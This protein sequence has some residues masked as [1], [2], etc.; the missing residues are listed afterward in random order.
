MPAISLPLV[1]KELRQ[2]LR[3]RATLAVENLYV[4]ALVVAATVSVYLANQS[5][6]PLWQ[7]G[8]DAFYAIAAM[9]SV[10]L[11]LVA[12][13][14][15]GAMVSGERE[16]KT[17]DILLAAPVRVRQVVRSKLVAAGLIVLA[18]LLLSLPISVIF[19]LLGGLTWPEVAMAY[20][21]TAVWL[22]LALSIGLLSSAMF[23]RT[24]AAVPFA[25]VVTATLDLISLGIAQSGWAPSA[26]AGLGGLALLQNAA[27]PDFFSL[28]VPIGAVSLL[29]C[30]SLAIC[31]TESAL[32]RVRLA[33]RRRAASQRIWLMVWLCLLSLLTL[34]AAAAPDQEMASPPWDDLL[35]FL[36]CQAGLIVV[37][38]VVFVSQV[39]RKADLKALTGGRVGPM[40]GI[41][42]SGPLAGARYVVLLSVLILVGWTAIWWVN[43]PSL[44]L[45]GWR[46][47]LGT[48][49]LVAGI[50]V[51]AL[52]AQFAAL[53]RRVRR[54]WARR[55]LAGVLVA[56]FFIGPPALQAWFWR[57]QDVPPPSSVV[58]L[59]TNPFAGCIVSFDPVAPMHGS[60]FA[61]G[62]ESIIP[63]GACTLLFLL[64]FG[65]C[66]LF[67]LWRV[68]LGYLTPRCSGRAPAD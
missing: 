65:L 41:F 11:G 60:P 46:A 42:G 58:L 16:Q 19:L 9:Q 10:L 61:E 67:V 37:F 50:W 7:C 49:C 55:V 25:I 36:S 26:I 3:A 4:L 29:L 43:G 32:D 66:L 31:L 15:A 1:R 56:L 59:L 64:A 57:G 14:F 8:R 28:K 27:S 35:G 13:A 33:H 18:L 24:I 6:V 21:I 52:L 63:L 30:L 68:R 54:G 34:G 48:A 39:P 62:I 2:S 44:E 47:A 22:T 51:A 40:D 5:G 45:P 23:Q 17:E 20:L 38:A 53:C 12:A